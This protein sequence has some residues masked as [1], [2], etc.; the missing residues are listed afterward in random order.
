MQKVPRMIFILPT[1]LVALMVLASS[2]G[3]FAAT[4]LG[5]DDG[6]SDGYGSVEEGAG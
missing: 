1:V 5:Y 6:S 3:V 4:E 2:Q